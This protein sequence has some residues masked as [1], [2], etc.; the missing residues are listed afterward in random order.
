MKTIS[1]LAALTTALLVGSATMAGP[2]A[3]ASAEEIG[4]IEWT[5]SPADGPRDAP[6][7]E[8]RRRTGQTSFSLN[9]N[10]DRLAEVRAALASAGTSGF[11]LVREP[12]VLTCHGAVRGAFDGHGTCRFATDEGFE[13]LLRARHLE[14]EDRGELLTMALLDVSRAMIE[15]FA[16]AGVPAKTSDELIA[17]AALKIS[18]DY[19]AE[20]RSAGLDLDS[21]EDTVACR[22]L[23]VD[24][25]YVR[26]LVEA[27]YRPDAEQV[28]AMKA[29]GVTPQYARRMTA[30]AQD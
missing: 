22:A 3:P 18:P 27:G 4:G 16:Q 11:T 8:F 23:D 14:L 5:V 30:A 6:S 1:Y 2:A 24:G 12:G 7:I 9:Q 26:A 15:G 10:D 29:V 28:V 13:E 25:A 17:A 20:L 21:I 19:V